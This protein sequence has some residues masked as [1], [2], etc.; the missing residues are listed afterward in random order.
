MTTVFKFTKR[1]YAQAAVELGQ[2]R[3]SHVAGF[4]VS[5]GISGG[6]SDPAELTSSANILNG[7]ETILSNN[8]GFGGMFTYIKNGVHV[9]AE[10]VISGASIEL[11]DSGL[12]FCTSLDNTDETFNRMRVDFGAEAA[13]EITDIDEFAQ[14]IQVHLGETEPHLEEVKA[15]I[16]RR[17][18]LPHPMREFDE[19]MCRYLKWEMERKRTFVVD[20]GPVTYYD[21]PSA[22]S[23]S[24]MP[25]VDPFRKAKSFE[26]QREHRI[27]VRPYDIAGDLDIEL[28]SLCGLLRLVR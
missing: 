21:G 14:Q 15:R 1:Q 26:W 19:A 23:V 8:P 7:E 4:R 18:D 2:F 13:Y 20:H 11:F 5:D 24:A 25:S 28:P 6:R 12:L 9:S 10:M 16:K 22:E 3:L 17:L 27:V